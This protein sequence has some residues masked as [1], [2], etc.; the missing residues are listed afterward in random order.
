[1]KNQRI[2]TYIG[3]GASMLSGCHAPSHPILTNPAREYSQEIMQ[4]YSARQQP[5]PGQ[6]E[7][8]GRTQTVATMIDTQGV[9]QSRARL[10][11]ADNDNSAT[12]KFASVTD[13]N[14][15]SGYYVEPSRM[16]NSRD[17]TGPLAVGE[18][19]VSASLWQESRSNNELFR[20][21]RAWQPM[22][23]LTIVVSEKS[24]GKKEANTEVKEQSTVQAAI[25]NL[26]GYETDLKKLLDSKTTGAAD[27]TKL[28]GASSQNDF[29]GEGKTNR[30][31]SLTAKISAMVAE[32]LPSGILRVE[33]KKI[34]SVNN[35]DETMVVSGLV[36]PVDINSSNEVSSSK[37]A[38]L[39]VDYYGDGS[40]GDAQQGGWA[41]NAV[42]KYWPF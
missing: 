30:K 35:E 33:G 37:S 42:R 5:Y 14:N 18:P 38:Q 19:G 26:L 6:T 23:L 10:R 28:L 8:A 39:R 34:I 32:V 21:D 2:A 7:R 24:E 31:G 40:V 27:V 20:D 12:V 3:L 11:Y 17:Y 9:D 13:T 22:D 36:R 1:M 41:G 15:Q 16:Q 4:Q 29:K 25:D